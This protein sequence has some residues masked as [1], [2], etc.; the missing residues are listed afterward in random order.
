MAVVSVT[1][2]LLVATTIDQSNLV[3]TEASSQ[4]ERSRLSTESLTHVNSGHFGGFERWRSYIL[5]RGPSPLSAFDVIACSHTQGVALEW[6]MFQRRTLP[7][8]LPAPPFVAGMPGLSSDLD[9]VHLSSE[10]LV[11]TY[12]FE[13]GV[14]IWVKSARASDV[15]LAV[16][17]H[18]CSDG[19][20]FERLLGLP[21]YKFGDQRGKVG[22][23]TSQVYEL[24]PEEKR[25]AASGAAE[26]VQKDFR[27]A[28]AASRTAS[29]CSRSKS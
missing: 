8:I 9:N 2:Q 3:A 12:I 7:L 21:V 16:C 13:F 14:K 19:A 24:S 4:N 10:I 1:K 11:E 23:S 22:P 25:A 5:L 20:A 29:V 27:A 6:K 15:G 26:A 17:E 18:C 28:N